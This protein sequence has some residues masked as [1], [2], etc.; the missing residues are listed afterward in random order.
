MSILKTMTIYEV[1]S[2]IRARTLTVR[3][4]VE[5]CLQKMQTENAKLHAVVHIS[6]S[7]LAEADIL[8]AEADAGNF[9]GPLHGVPLLIKDN[10]NVRGMPTTVGSAIFA[11]TPP[12]E[13]DCEVVARLRAAGAVLM[14]KTNMDEFA[15]HVSGMTSFHGPTL[16]PWSTQEPLSPGGSSSGAAAAVAA[17]FCCAGLGTDTGGSIRLPAGWCGVCGLRPTHGRISL[18][19]IYPRATSLDTVGTLARTVRDLALLF[20]IMD[21]SC[22]QCHSLSDTEPF[23]S[24]ACLRIGIFSDFVHREARPEVASLYDACVEHWQRLGAHCTPTALPLLLD[25]RMTDTIDLIR[26]YEFARDIAVDVETS[27]HRARMHS[28]STTD[29]LRGRQISIS[30]YDAALERTGAYAQEIEDFFQ[31]QNL[32]FLLLP[33]AF[34]TAPQL[35]L[36]AAVFASGRSLVNLFSLTGVPSLVIPAGLTTKGLPLGIQLVGSKHRDHLLLQAGVLYESAY[37]PFPMPS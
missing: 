3:A 18:S 12:V 16:N 32:D 14:G 8:D 15:A 13:T 23:V 30:A 31:T 20:S 10:M 37:G 4:I 2:A 1:S 29:Y 6:V 24:G 28:I 25:E 27:P 9:R 11:D 26:S 7:A 17:G 22:G 36:D 19:G 21:T 33:V 5:Y 35:I 34:S